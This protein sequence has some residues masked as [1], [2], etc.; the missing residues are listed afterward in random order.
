MTAKNYNV[1]KPKWALLFKDMPRAMLAFV[2]L[3]EKGTVKYSRLNF[4]ESIGTPDAGRFK[5]EN[6]ESIIRHCVELL[7]GREIDPENGEHHGANIMC[8]GAFAVEYGPV[9]LSDKECEDV[10]LKC[11]ESRYPW[12]YAPEWATCA[13]IDANGRGFYYGSVTRPHSRIW[14][15]NGGSKIQQMGHNMLRDGEDWRG[16]L[17]VRP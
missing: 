7:A 2:R 11:I 17:E 12:K 1:G 10:S 5:E 15:A 4:A 3:R 6:L 8:R 9:E 14:S 16:T 13:A